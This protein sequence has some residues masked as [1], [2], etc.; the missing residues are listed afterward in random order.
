MRTA[1]I[2]AISYALPTEVL[3]QSALEERFGVKAVKSITRMS[4]ITERR[5]VAPGQTAADLSYAAA[6]RLIDH[7]KVDPASIDLLT[8]A[9]QT[10]DYKIPATSCVLHGRLGLSENCC[11]FD[12]NQ[13]CSSFMHSLRIAHGMLTAGTAKRALV[14]N[15]D[16][17]TTLINPLDRGLATLHGDGAAAALLEASED[18]G[19]EFIDIG[20]DSSKYDR[21][22][23]PAGASRCPGSTET[24]VEAQ[25][26][27]GCMRSPEQL[28]MDGPAI[29]HFA[30]YKMPDLIRNALKQRNLSI[31]D[32]DKVLFHQ[33]NKT[34]L[35]LMYKAIGAGNEKKF[36]FL[37]HTGN[38]SGA[39]LPTLLAE[40]WRQGEIKPGSRTLLC[41]FGGGLSWGI[42]SIKWPLDANAAV[43]G[44]VDVLFG[45]EEGL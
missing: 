38:S 27:D 11:T 43:P 6:K 23:V 29:F 16:A 36:Y 14:L 42:A 30:V 21:L 32:F 45:Q 35:E 40:A 18:G 12:I 34:M 24:K 5:I 3:T 10:P 13:A 44:D 22:I 26:E 33:A 7:L 41:S 25:D 17:L 19:L 8:F 15:G 28:F 1:T 9:S 4:G 2:K 39:S 31:E 20:T 37:E